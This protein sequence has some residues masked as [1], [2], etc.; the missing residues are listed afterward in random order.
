MVTIGL[1]RNFGRE[2]QSDFLRGYA[3]AK[4]SNK[5]R[6]RV[7]FG[8]IEGD[9]ESI[10]EGLRSIAATLNKAFQTAPTIVQVLSAEKET[11]EKQLVEYV[12][13]QLAEQPQTN[14]GP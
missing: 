1:M 4:D 13:E 2:Y 7:F 9:N 10:R 3:M 14:G 12:E 5:A 8:E 11:N 6:V